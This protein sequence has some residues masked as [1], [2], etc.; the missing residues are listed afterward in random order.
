[1]R[2]EGLPRRG[3]GAFPQAAESRREQEVALDDGWLADLLEEPAG[4]GEPAPRLGDLAV[5][6]VAKA[7]P[8][9]RCRCGD[10]VTLIECRVVRALPCGLALQRA[11]EHVG[12]NRQAP[13]VLEA[14]RRRDPW[15]GESGEC[16]R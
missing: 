1:D 9:R 6:D 7:H 13:E 2:L 11:A 3:D 15:V 4:S 5:L 12:G 14:E 8:E 10:K 16:L